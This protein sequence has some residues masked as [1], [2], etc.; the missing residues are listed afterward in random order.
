MKNYAKV[1]SKR[2]RPAYRTQAA[3]RFRKYV[4]LKGKVRKK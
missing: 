2:G 1:G 3:F 4:S